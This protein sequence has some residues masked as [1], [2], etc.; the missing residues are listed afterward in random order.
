MFSAPRCWGPTEQPHVQPNVEPTPT[1]NSTLRTKQQQ[2]KQT[3][4][5]T[6]QKSLEH[7]TS[8]W[9]GKI[10][11]SSDE[12]SNH[13]LH[14]HF[15]ATANLDDVWQP[16][17][18]RSHSGGGDWL[19]SANVLGFYSPRPMYTPSPGE[20][21]NWRQTGVQ[22]VQRTNEQIRYWESKTFQDS[23]GYEIEKEWRVLSSSVF[24]FFCLSFFL[25]SPDVILCGWLGLKHQ[26]TNYFFLSLIGCFI[27]IYKP[28]QWGPADTEIKDLSVENQELKVSSLKAWSNTEYSHARLTCCQGFLPWSNLH[29]PGPFDFIFTK[30]LQSF[31][32]LA[33]TNAGTCVGHQNK[34]RSPCSLSE[35]ND[36]RSHVERVRNINRL[37]NVSFCITMVTDIVMVYRVHRVL[38]EELKTVCFIGEIS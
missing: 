23:G 36:T 12:N 15:S 28:R 21:K 7:S 34:N 11:F 35:K 20:K 1:K 10:S 8:K 29:L 32:V 25:S 18:T 3:N 16:V 2:N 5:K 14:S 31:P 37:Q 30:S 6:V 27:F 33:K 4:K 13:L 17:I 9:Q 24:L 22:Q 19:T 26:L 38:S